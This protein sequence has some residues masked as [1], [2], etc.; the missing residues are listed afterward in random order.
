MVPF[1]SLILALTTGAVGI[2]YSRMTGNKPKE[3]RVDERE[4]LITTLNEVKRELENQ[5]HQLEGQ[6]ER[7]ESEKEENKKQL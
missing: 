5:K 6:L 4:P 7:V 1:S 2:A 3:G